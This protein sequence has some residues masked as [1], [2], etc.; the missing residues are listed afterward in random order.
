MDFSGKINSDSRTFSNTSNLKRRYDIDWL[1][2]IAI[3]L[4][5]IHHSVL[6]F[7]PW[8]KFIGFPANDQTLTDIWFLMAIINI[9]RIPILFVISGMGVCFAMER[10]NWKEL[11]ID[12]SL[13]ILVPYLAGIILFEYLITFILEYFELANI[14]ITFGHLWFLLNIYLY[15]LWSIGVLIYLKDNPNNA[16]F[17]FLEK[18][19][20]YRYGILIFTLPFILEAVLVNPESYTMFVDS[21]HGWLLGLISFFT[22]FL[23]VSLGETFW[24][25]VRKIRWETLS[26]AFISYLIRFVIFNFEGTPNILIAFESICW[27]L[28]ILG[29]GSIHLNKRS[30]TLEYF[31]KAV[32]PVYI[33]HLPIQFALSYYILPLQLSAE[34]KLLLLIGCTFCLSLLLYEFILRRIKYIR[35]LFGMKFNQ[36]K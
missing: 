8:A 22:G 30:K 19:L 16:L 36:A 3:A 6:T 29:F 10:R 23:F 7:Q 11:L 2:T 27:I 33:V 35:P 24:K 1:R 28:T 20:H 18:M 25:S 13:R 17:R 26:I 9:W 5:I 31:S 21:V 34:M 15:T 4:L 14:K 12:R 32:Y